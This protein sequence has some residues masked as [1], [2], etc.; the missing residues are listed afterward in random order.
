MIDITKLVNELVEDVKLLKR[1]IESNDLIELKYTK[2]SDDVP[3]PFY[4]TDGSVAF[5]ICSNEDVVIYP[6]ETK[7]IG[8]GLRFSIPKGYHLSVRPRSGIS[9]RTTIWLKNSP[10]TIDTDYT[11]ELGLILY[12]SGD[13]EYKCHRFDRLAQCILERSVLAKFTNV[14]TIIDTESRGS[15]GFGSTGV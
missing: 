4:A 1:Q 12:N 6:Y 5:D 14:E 9:L 3:D 2:L 13:Y 7:L 10:G 11:G 15:N 8:T